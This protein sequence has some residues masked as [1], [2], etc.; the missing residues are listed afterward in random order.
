LTLMVEATV[1]LGNRESG[2]GKGTE[3]KSAFRFI[4][5][6]RWQEK[7]K[8]PTSPPNTPPRG[9][10]LSTGKGGGS[11]LLDKEMGR[12]KRVKTKA[13]SLT[14]LLHT[15]NKE[16]MVC[17]G[18]EKGKKREGKGA[19]LSLYVD[20][21]KEEKPQGRSRLFY[22]IDGGSGAAQERKKMEGR[23][24]HPTSTLYLGRKE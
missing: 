18:R 11:S 19:F 3:R 2:E 5:I 21:K 24:V 12:K 6:S 22:T 20:K 4:N 7:E 17:R 8:S 1:L 9:K 10:G 14:I 13:E 16:E 23:E 15:A